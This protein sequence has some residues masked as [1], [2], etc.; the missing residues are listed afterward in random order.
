MLTLQSSKSRIVCLLMF[1]VNQDSIGDVILS[2]SKGVSFTEVQEALNSAALQVL[3]SS[4]STAE[5][6]CV[7]RYLTMFS[8]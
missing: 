7:A 4:A 5:L 6:G 1:K 2:T 8:R 3:L